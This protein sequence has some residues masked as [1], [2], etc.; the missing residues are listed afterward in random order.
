MKLFRRNRQA[1]FS[2]KSRAIFDYPITAGANQLSVS[3]MEVYASKHYHTLEKIASDIDEAFMLPSVDFYG[4]KG[5]G[6]AVK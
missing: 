1:N 2:G 6:M 3:I 4:V 5:G